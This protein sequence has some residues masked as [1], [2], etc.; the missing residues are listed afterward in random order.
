MEQGNDS[1][2][3]TGQVPLAHSA[4]D[5]VP[6]QTYAD[7][8]GH[9]CDGTATRAAAMLRFAVNPLP[10]LA[11]EIGDAATWHDLGKLDAENQRELREGETGRPPWDHV[12]A[13]V[14]HLMATGHPV[15]AWLVRAHH[16]PGLPAEA[17][18]FNQFNRG[19]KLRGRRNDDVPHDEHQKQKAWTDRRLAKYLAAHQAVIPTRTTTASGTQSEVGQAHGLTMRLALSC[20]VDAD[21]ADTA[22]HYSGVTSPNE[23]GDPRWEERLEQLTRYVRGLPAGA[24]P[25]EQ[26]RNRRR[27]DFYEACLAS[28]LDDP[29]VACEGPVGI[30][31]TTAVVAYLIR[32]AMRQTPRQRRLIIVA[33]YTNI[34]S[35]TA[36]R[37]REALVLPDERDEDVVAEHHH[38]ADFECERDRDLAVLWRAPIV[39]TTAVSFFEALSAANPA[40]LRKLHAVPGSAVFVD[41]AHAAL[42]TQLWPQNWKWVRELAHSWGCRFVMA[43]GSL[44][45][46][47]EDPQIVEQTCSLPELMPAS[48]AK[49]AHAA[50]QNR[51]HYS[52]L[53][54]ATNGGSVLD[55]AELVSEVLAKPGPSLVILNTVQSA[56]VVARK[57]CEQAGVNR[58][59]HLSTALTPYDRGRILKR[60]HKKLASQA[61]NWALVATSCVEAGVDLSFQTA[62]RER[63]A[64]ASILQTAGR[65]NRH[66]ERGRGDVFD[67]SLTGE[68]VTQHPAAET[69]APV[70][71]QLMKRDELNLRSPAEVVSEAMR[72]ELLDKGGLGHQP[73]VKAE[74]EHD[75]PAAQEAGRVI[76]SD[77]RLVVVDPQLQ[78]DLSKRKHVGFRRLLLGSVQLWAR[79]IE[80]L[81]LAPVPGRQDLYVWNDAYEP[82]F[83]G[84]MAGVLRTDAF[85]AA[86]G[87]VI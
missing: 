32:Q 42:P 22:R 81:G 3:K 10:W 18:H 38:R 67:F 76:T 4:R 57:I 68:N 41:E 50:E 63:F 73:L 29:L 8:V 27:R 20:L 87:G 61:N 36:N 23:A 84:I 1:G 5:G 39:L 31:K 2:V 64:A 48:Q 26:E 65:V 59:L 75:Y 6:A 17:H 74:N 12:D 49:D 35:Q 19:N 16:A 52:I 44:A 9:V 71:L 55:V 62:F 47:W 60:I 82:D 79:R 78:A 25:E 34:L 46:F 80:S 66:S 30:G 43:S 83:L 85:L 77:T 70:L 37:L 13:G 51:V 40:A 14:A 69:S 54:S 33:P 24:T 28:D 15:A 21:H 56:A 45:R 11:T 72:R 86:G 58:V 7:H 53:R